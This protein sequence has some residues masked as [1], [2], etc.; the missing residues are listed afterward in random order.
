M[1][2][3]EHT[4]DDDDDEVVLSPEALK[5]LKEFY[6]E[7]SSSS[8]DFQENW[9]LSQFWYNQETCE[10][11]T[12]EIEKQLVERGG[13]GK[14]GCVCTPTL[15]R[16]LWDNR[17]SLRE[18]LY[19]FDIDPR[20]ETYGK[21]FRVYDFNSPESLSDVGELKDKF[22]VLI[23]DPPYLNSECFQQVWTTLNLLSVKST[24]P[25]IIFLTGQVMLE[26][27]QNLS[28]GTIKETKFK[29]GHVNNLGNQFACFANF[30]PKVLNS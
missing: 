4:Q 25:L 30:A 3:Q 2:S 11:V 28:A 18:R 13:Q 9:K 15:F 14:I 23:V 27:L 6:A 26:T 29:P 20:F 22:E 12:E 21:N 17:P 16:H 5:A 10:I 8:S 1:K 24:T 19:V 7:N